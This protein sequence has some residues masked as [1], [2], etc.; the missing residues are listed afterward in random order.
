HASTEHDER[1]ADRNVETHCEG[2]RT[3]PQQLYSDHQKHAN[4]NQP[5]GQLALQNPVDHGGHQARLWPRGARAADALHPLHFDLAA[6]GIVEILAI[7][8]G[9]RVDSVEQN[10]SLHGMTDR[11]AS[12]WPLR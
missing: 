4:E 5:P 8:H 12:G 10:V 9:W 11:L 2:E 3:D 1:D 6:G 7:G